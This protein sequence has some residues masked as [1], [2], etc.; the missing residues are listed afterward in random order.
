MLVAVKTC[1][2]PYSLGAKNLEAVEGTRV[3]GNRHW[4][5]DTT[6]MDGQLSRTV[7]VLDVYL[8]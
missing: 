2:S 4:P 3:L 5:F 6:G 1:I 8:K 7:L